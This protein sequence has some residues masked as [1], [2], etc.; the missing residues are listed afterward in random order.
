MVGRREFRATRAC[1]RFQHVVSEENIGFEQS[2]AN[3]RLVDGEHR[4]IRKPRDRR[5]EQIR[6]SKHDDDRLV[7]LLLP[8]PICAALFQGTFS[9]DLALQVDDAESRRG[10]RLNARPRR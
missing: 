2:G 6:L 4:E 10:G 1:K 8:R 7:Q 3:G 5:L 9:A